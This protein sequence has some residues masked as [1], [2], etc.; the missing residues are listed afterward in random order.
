MESQLVTVFQF[1]VFDFASYFQEISGS[2]NDLHTR[3]TRLGE[4]NFLDFL[5]FLFMQCKPEYC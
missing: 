1:G 5:R 3:E 2:L 4:I